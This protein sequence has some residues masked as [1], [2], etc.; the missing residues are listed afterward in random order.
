MS[1]TLRD[2]VVSL[3]L[4]SDNF[5][6]KACRLADN[7]HEIAEIRKIIGDYNRGQKIDRQKVIE[8]ITRLKGKDASIAAF[9]SLLNPG[10]VLLSEATDEQI[11][12]NLNV[13]LL[14]LSGK[15]TVEGI[16]DLIGGKKND[17]DT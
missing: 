7:A 3:S 4:N 6:R 10:C 11:I 9:N 1:E 12:E 16:K 15:M 8:I 14:Y 17:S 2:L 5:T 13:T